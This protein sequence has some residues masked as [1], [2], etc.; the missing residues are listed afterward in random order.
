MQALGH[1]Q[2]ELS[3]VLSRIHQIRNFS[4]LR[5]PSRN[6]ISGILFLWRVVILHFL[7]AMAVQARSGHLTR[8]RRNV[9]WVQC[10]N[11]RWRIGAWHEDNRVAEP[12]FI[13]GLERQTR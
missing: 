2:D 5:R 13:L 3:A 4:S 7:T 9:D 10:N 8:Y 11:A 6:P 1:A 12:H